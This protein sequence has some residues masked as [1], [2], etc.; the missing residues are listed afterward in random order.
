M[1]S[2]HPNWRTTQ[3]CLLLF[4]LVLSAA[5]AAPLRFRRTSQ[6]TTTIITT[7]T[8]IQT[9]QTIRDLLSSFD[10][11]SHEL[12]TRSM[13]RAPQQSSSCTSVVPKIEDCGG[14]IASN[15]SYIVAN[16]LGQMEAR[17]IANLDNF[18]MKMETYY[19]DVSDSCENSAR[20]FFCS[21][22]FRTCTETKGQVVL[23]KPCQ[24]LCRDLYTNC[25]PD[26][27]VAEKS[28]DNF[29]GTWDR[30]SD[31]YGQ[32]PT[33]TDVFYEQSYDLFFWI[34]VGLFIP[35]VLIAVV[36]CSVIGFMLC[37]SSAKDKSPYVEQEPEINYKASVNAGVFK[38][39]VKSS[40]NDVIGDDAESAPLAI[41]SQ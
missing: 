4:L 28:A 36:T 10:Q 16:S 25:I 18:L 6:P 19:G 33:C 15:V 23:Q 14:Y 41:S 35:S 7:Q 1:T 32:R 22:S 24:Y 40:K 8:H 17:M 20:N 2:G 12:E 30:P 37:Y 13:P 38:S 31:E 34:G 26:S 3:C 9:A 11:Q 21:R 27:E 5:T 39:V 29:C